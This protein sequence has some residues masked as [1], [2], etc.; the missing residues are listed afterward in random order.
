MNVIRLYKPAL[1]ELTYRQKLI[2][3]EATMAYNRKWGGTIDWPRDKWAPWA[4]RWLISDEKLYFYRYILDAESG[5]YVGEAAFR[6]DE[7]Y[8]MHVISII[9]EAK[10]RGKGYG[11]AALSNLIKAAKQMH[12]TCLCDDIAVDNPSIGMFRQFGFGEKWRT[13]EIVMLVMDLEG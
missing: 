13:D 4:K 1:E 8:G 2:A 9:V 5:E 7:E 10:H 6:Y 12:I 3:D 11:K